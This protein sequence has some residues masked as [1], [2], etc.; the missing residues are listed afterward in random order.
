MQVPFEV[1]FEDMLMNGDAEIMELICVLVYYIWRTRNRL[2]F[3]GKDSLVQEMMH[4]ALGE[5]HEFKEV[6]MVAATQPLGSGHGRRDR[7]RWC[8]PE[9][10]SYKLNTDA[11]MAIGGGRT[12]Q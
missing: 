12:G 3:E 7:V 6:N 11:T 8:P 1:W 4:R 9:A 10:G 2:C 5:L